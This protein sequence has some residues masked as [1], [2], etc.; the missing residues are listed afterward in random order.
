ME[1]S[2]R[3]EESEVVGRTSKRISKHDIYKQTE[4]KARALRIAIEAADVHALRTALLAVPIDG[5][6]TGPEGLT[7]QL[8]EPSHHEKSLMEKSINKGRVMGLISLKG[9]G[10]REM[11][12]TSDEL[13]IADALNLLTKMA[14]RDERLSFSLT[15]W[16]PS[17][18][19]ISPEVD[20]RYLSTLVQ[21]F[22]RVDFRVVF[23]EEGKVRAIRIK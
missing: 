4:Q 3:F 21:A 11:M 6:L 19:P 1:S 9:K 14:G 7:L 18:S 12:G 22:P 8:A 20:R 5:K 10:G 17:K 13:P 16:D 2:K 23:K 15:E